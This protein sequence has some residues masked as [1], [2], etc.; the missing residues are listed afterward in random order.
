MMKGINRGVTAGI[1]IGDSMI[2]SKK[3]FLKICLQDEK[4]LS[5]TLAKVLG[6]NEQQS[7]LAGINSEFIVKY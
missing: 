7:G 2:D 3:E 5:I 1:Y 4:I 6:I